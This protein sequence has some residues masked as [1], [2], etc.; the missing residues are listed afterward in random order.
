M[1]DVPADEKHRMPEVEAS[2]FP[3]MTPVAALLVVS[4]GIAVSPGTEA[5]HTNIAV[6]MPLEAV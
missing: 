6:W 3:V 2:A 1:V 5:G 4:V